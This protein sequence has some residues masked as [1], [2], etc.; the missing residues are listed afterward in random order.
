[1]LLA[2]ISKIYFMLLLTL[3]LQAV[4]VMTQ[5][6][7]FYLY[8]KKEQIMTSNNLNKFCRLKNNLWSS[9]NIHLFSIT[10]KM[11][12]ATTISHI[13]KAHQKS[14]SPPDANFSDIHSGTNSIK[15]FSCSSTSPANTNEEDHQ[16]LPE[17]RELYTCG[18]NAYFCQQYHNGLQLSCV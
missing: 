3:L 14:K 9:T 12:P 13:N 18:T 16:K 10:I 17:K 5:D 4:L 1:M 2:V 7:T 11:D 15:R 6:L 8:C